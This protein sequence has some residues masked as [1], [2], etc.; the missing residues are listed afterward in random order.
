VDTAYVQVV[1]S[2]TIKVL[3]EKLKLAEEKDQFYKSILTSS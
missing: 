2:A 3:Q 1:D